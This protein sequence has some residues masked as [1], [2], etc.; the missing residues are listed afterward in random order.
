MRLIELQLENFR[1][2]GHFAADFSGIDLHILR[3]PNGAGKS[4]V[5]EAISLLSL[6][7][8]AGIDDDDLIGWGQAY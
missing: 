2:F 5:L 7:K 3:G 1:S 8:A 6:S 4:N